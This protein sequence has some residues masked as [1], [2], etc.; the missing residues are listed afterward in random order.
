MINDQVVAITGASSGIGRATVSYLAN[1]RGKGGAWRSARRGT[2]GDSQQI[3]AKVVKSIQR[4]TMSCLSVL[5][6]GGSFER[7]DQMRLQCCYRIHLPDRPR[8]IRDTSLR[9]RVK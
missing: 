8:R 9:S 4:S 5:P 1:S 2:N 7:V 6:D 3:A